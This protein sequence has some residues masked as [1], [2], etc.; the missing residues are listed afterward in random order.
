M[1]YLNSDSS[2]K[3]WLHVSGSHTLED[4]AAEVASAVQQPNSTT[5][6]AEASLHHPVGE[7]GDEAPR[8]AGD[9]KRTAFTIGALGAGSDYVAFLDYLGVASMNAGFAGQ[10]K[11]GIYHSI[12]D[13]IYWY[14]HFSDGSFVDGKALAE[15]TATALM[16]LADADVLPF[17]FGHFVSTVSG[18]LDEIQKEAKRKGQPL[19]F[20]GLMKQLDALKQNGE[21]Y[22]S[23]LTAAL[24]KGGLDEARVSAVNDALIRTERALTHAEGLPNRDWYKHQ[25]YA[26][27]FYTGYGVKTVPG[28]REAVDSGDWPL[29]KK[30]AAIVETCLSQMNRE[31]VLAMNGLSGI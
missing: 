18:Y 17:E 11:G 9:K 15:Y 26:P 22:D 4:F 1:A 27:G 30:E 25:I 2:A 20:A 6:L 5:N 14:T 16:R 13:S 3:G 12:Y 10:T 8:T 28:V 21:K 7:E 23:L 29:A 24:E 31:V 19:D